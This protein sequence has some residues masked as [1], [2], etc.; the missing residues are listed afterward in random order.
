MRIHNAS[1]EP[2]CRPPR[3]GPSR[4]LH[5]PPPHRCP[6]GIGA[7]G[8]PASPAT[9][10]CAVI[11]GIEMLTFGLMFIIF[12]FARMREPSVFHAGHGTLDLHLGAP[13]TPR[14]S[15]SAAGA[16]RAA[17][18]LR[19]HGG[20]A[21][22][23]GLWAAGFRRRIPAA[24]IR[25]A[26]P[27]RAPADRIPLQPLDLLLPVTIGSTSCTCWLPCCCYRHRSAGAAG[28]RVEGRQH[29]R[30]GNRD[31]VQAHGR[32]T[33]RAVPAGVRAAIECRSID[34]PWWATLAAPTACGCGGSAAMT[35]RGPG[36]LWPLLAVFGLSPFQGTGH[37]ARFLCEL[38]RRMAVWSAASS[39]GWN[40]AGDP[41]RP[42]LLHLVRAICW[43]TRSPCAAHA[44]QY[45]SSR[46]GR[47]TISPRPSAGTS[48]T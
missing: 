37:R 10:R 12:S 39:I 45:P 29:A 43:L 19:R 32:P 23:A 2:A 5:T 28:A 25:L 24:Q 41:R 44:S 35:G 34:E 22:P 26:G 48:N 30:A 46:C 47:C 8:H 20:A 15:P 27:R 33:G 16:R 9:S 17:Q 18:M 1:C 6:A 21:A 14:C 38:R 42:W 31:G 7:R 3:P 36:P 4:C 40:A 13:R 11:I